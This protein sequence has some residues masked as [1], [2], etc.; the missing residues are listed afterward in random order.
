MNF[1]VVDQGYTAHTFDLVIAT[2]MSQITAEIDETVKQARKLLKPGGYLF[3]EVTHNQQVGLDSPL[4]E[5]NDKKL[6]LEENETSSIC[7]SVP[8]WVELVQNCGFEGVNWMATYRSSAPF[9]CH[10]MLTQAVDHRIRFLHNPLAQLPE[11]VHFP[12][13]VLIGG[14]TD[15]TSK[16]LSDVKS[17]MVTRTSS[18]SHVEALEN[19]SDVPIPFGGTVVLFQDHDKPVFENLDEQKLKGLQRL[20]ENAKNVLWITRGYK[21]NS[22]Y[23]RMA[24][25]FVRCILQEMSHVRLQLLDIPS[26][27][28]LDASFISRHLLRLLVTQRWEEEGLIEDILWS[29]EPEICHENGQ[30]Y[31][32]RVKLNKSSNERYNSARRQ[33]S[34]FVDPLTTPV[35]PVLKDGSYVLQSKHGLGPLQTSHS[36]NS[37]SVRVSHSLLK[38]IKLET[39]DYVFLVLGTDCLTGER[40][41][42]L[43]NCLASVV[44]VPSDLVRSCSTKK[45]GAAQYLHNLFYD[46]I[47]RTMLRNMSQGDSLLVLEPD[48]DLANVIESLASSRGIEVLFLT[49]KDESHSQ[50]AWKKM[51]RRPLLR[52]VE[53]A[54]PCQ[55]SRI[56]CCQQNDW[57]SS[58]CGS[59]SRSLNI[60]TFESYLNVEASY[61]KPKALSRLSKVLDSAQK[62]IVPIDSELPPKEGETISLQEIQSSSSSGSAQIVVDW[63]GTSK[64]SMT[65]EPV[66]QRPLFRSDRTYWLVGLTGGLGLSLCQWMIS[67][68]ARYIVISSRSPEVD[69]RWSAHF[70]SLG[71]IVK[72]C[73]ND[74]TNRESVRSTH[75]DIQ[76]SMP[77]IAGVCHGAMVLHD[78]LLQDLDISRVENT[79]KPKICGAIYLDEIFQNQDLDFFVMISSISAITGNPGQA[80]YAAANGFLAGLAA[81]RRARGVTASTINLGAIMGNGYVTRKLTLAQQ[82]SLEKAG[83]MWMSEQDFHQAFAEAVVASPLIPE[84]SGELCTGIRVCYAED[85]HKPKHAYNPIFSHLLFHRS[86]LEPPARGSEPKISIKTQLVQTTTS[87]EVSKILQGK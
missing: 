16:C 59:F 40:V 57:I 71:A 64:V 44:D 60:E 52:E 86:V 83:V 75:E 66:D 25:A 58:L 54:L 10:L 5:L 4:G 1:D 50:G 73:T 80:A 21:Q 56:V 38:A 27:G 19:L 65:V 34:R 70:E 47:S 6:G 45:Y 3:L 35:T 17:D 24:V 48:K 32:P 78:S 22:P 39:S 30:E 18:L 77:Q 20:F 49:T 8:K 7:A 67:R 53:A 42:A 13:I 63:T 68:G 84:S 55:I 43:S 82:T 26:T 28:A 15:S 11:A 51:H 23:A 37:T 9:L 46:L 29:V 33:I 61:L 31:I 74:V 2:S 79:F 69:P 62:E 41:F 85:D 12:G 76:L 14:A 87:E 36:A 72:V 81:Q